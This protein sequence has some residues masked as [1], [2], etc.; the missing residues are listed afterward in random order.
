MSIHGRKK[1]SGETRGKDKMT[2]CQYVVVSAVCISLTR[3][4]KE[5]FVLSPYAV[6]GLCNFKPHA[7]ML[8]GLALLHEF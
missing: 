4:E 3:N 8:N 7:D 5:V 1:A 6:V 2:K